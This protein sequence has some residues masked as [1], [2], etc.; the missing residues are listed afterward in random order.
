MDIWTVVV[1]N[2]VVLACVSR[3]TTKKDRQLIERR[4]VHPQKNTPGYAYVLF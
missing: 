2:L 4:K 3:V 1:V